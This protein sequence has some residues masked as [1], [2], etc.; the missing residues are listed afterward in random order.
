M[1][2]GH[3]GEDCNVDP[4]NLNGGNVKI[5]VMHITS[6]HFNKA[7]AKEARGNKL[8]SLKLISSNTI[9]HI[10]IICVYLDVESQTDKNT[11]ERVW[12]KLT[13]K[14]ELALR[15]GEGV[16]FL[17]DLNRPLQ[18]PTPSHRTKLLLDWERNG[19]IKILNDRTVPTRPSNR[20]GFC[21]GPWFGVC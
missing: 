18:A 2:I 3:V 15:R 12:T 13:N 6:K 8:L 5:K 4:V 14:V 17:G 20:E 9:P 19:L 11:V 10:K 1:K 16:V 21:R 7:Q